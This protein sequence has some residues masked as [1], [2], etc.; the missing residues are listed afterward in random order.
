MEVK[1]TPN[2]WRKE[3]D[4][5]IKRRCGSHI[6]RKQRRIKRV[7][8]IKMHHLCFLA[9]QLMDHV[10]NPHK[11]E[12]NKKHNDMTIREYRNEL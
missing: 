1:L 5:G 9:A 8:I 11:T 12:N 3:L 6:K 10:S 7:Y 4:A 2:L